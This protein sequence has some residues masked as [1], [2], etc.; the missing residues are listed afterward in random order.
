[1]VGEVQVFHKH[2][3]N[4]PEIL[5]RTQTAAD[6]LHDPYGAEFRANMGAFRKCLKEELCAIRAVFEE[7]NSHVES[8][9][10]G[11]VQCTAQI[12]H[13]VR[14]NIAFVEK[15]TEA[16]TEMQRLLNEEVGL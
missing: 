11:P 6:I 2:L 16:R 7:W 3:E 15:A 13:M 5:A 12:G 8:G 1:M 14:V 4:L 10:S 9:M